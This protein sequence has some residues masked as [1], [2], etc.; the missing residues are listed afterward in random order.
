MVVEKTT[1]LWWKWK[2][3]VV[4]VVVVKERVA[5]GVGESVQKMKRTLLR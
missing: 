3:E 5:G 2:R 1:S 4:G